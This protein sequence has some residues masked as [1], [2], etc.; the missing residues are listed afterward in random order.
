MGTIVER[1][2]DLDAVVVEKCYLKPRSEGALMVAYGPLQVLVVGV[3]LEGVVTMMPG[4]VAGPAHR[5]RVEA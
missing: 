4:V 5:R 3:H 2:V 1:F